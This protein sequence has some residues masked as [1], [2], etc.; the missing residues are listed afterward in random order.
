M[1][2]SPGM[3]DNLTKVYSANKEEVKEVIIEI[4]SNSFYTTP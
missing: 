1:I 2:L 4:P 3:G